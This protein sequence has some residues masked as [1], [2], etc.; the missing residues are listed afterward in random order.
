[1]LNVGHCGVCRSVGTEGTLDSG[2][3]LGRLL[4]GVTGVVAPMQPNSGE[5]GDKVVKLSLVGFAVRGARMEALKPPDGGLAESV[6]MAGGH[7]HVICLK[8]GDSCRILEFGDSLTAGG[9]KAND[10][11]FG[12]SRMV[13]VRGILEVLVETSTVGGNCVGG[14]EGGRFFCVVFSVV[15]CVVCVVLV[16]FGGCFDRG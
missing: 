11:L 6:E 16:C 8:E 14:G 2:E 13:L 1:M 10:D 9:V 4:L 15:F 5:D 12:V 3:C 7:T